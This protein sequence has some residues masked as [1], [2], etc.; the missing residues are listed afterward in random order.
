MDEPDIHIL[1]VG[2]ALPGAPVD[3]ATLADRFN[4][5][6]VWELWI[7]SFIGTRTRHFA[8]DL[9]TGTI[10][11]SLADLG[12]TAAAK[13]LQGAGLR[14]AD[15]DVMVLGT[16]SPDM[17]M[18][19]TVNLIADRLGIDDVP[20]FQLQS[21]CSGAVQAL[22]VAHKMLLS[23][24]YRN[25]LVLGAENCAKHIDLS[26][27]AASLPTSEQVNG[28]LFGDGAGAVVLSTEPRPGTAVLR[29][30]FLRLVGLGRAPGQ[31]VE[32][33][34]RGDRDSDRQPI[35]EDYKAIE[36][37]VPSM[38]A[39]TLEEMLEA[40]DWKE[41]DIDYLLPPQLSG[42]MTEKITERLD[43]PSAQ[44][45]S[46]VVDIGNTGNALPFFQLE[47][48]LP[49]MTTGDRTVGI[50]IESSKWIKAGFALEVC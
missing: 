36:Q 21:G 44:E 31:T 7:D 50:A 9:E 26:T 3:N 22:D 46:C 12:E 48:A 4:M 17:L 47:R 32:W 20:T 5:P 27:D 19:A 49:R 14:A 30:V 10:R 34:G 8:L 13:A 35:S 6:S 16:A 40:L 28:V 38:A 33:F 18:P 1:S 23:G 25:A 39:E 45:I 15:V 41:T 43:V 29:H 37:S 42:T 2:T 24:R 11:Y